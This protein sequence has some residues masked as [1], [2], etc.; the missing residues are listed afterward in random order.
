MHHWHIAY[1]PQILGLTHRVTPG[2]G[3]SPLAPLAASIF[4]AL[5]VSAAV[6]EHGEEWVSLHNERSVMAFEFEH[7]KDLARAKYNNRCLANVQRLRRTVRGEHAGYADMFVPII[8][9]KQVV[10]VLV[11]GPF[12]LRRPTATEVLE[13]WRALTRRQGDPAD[14]EFNAYLSAA[15]SVL[16]LDEEQIESF[17]QL[18]DCLARLMA[19]EGKADKLM[20]RIEV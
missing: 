7:G 3:H 6:Y 19:G 10:A 13:R 12:A 5:R 20:N 18:L 17:E 11:T 1:A 14:H 4:Q 16:V 9:K 15:L 8:A 2:F